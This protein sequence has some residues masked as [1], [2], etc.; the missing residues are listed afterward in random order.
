MKVCN[1]AALTH[2]GGTLQGGTIQL[3][4]FD[5]PF[6]GAATLQPLGY[7]QWKAL[8]KQAVVV[9]VKVKLEAWNSGSTGILV[10]LNAMPESKGTTLLTQAEA[11]CELPNSVHR[12]LSPDVDHATVFLKVSTKKHMAVSKLRDSNELAIDLPNETPPSRQSYMHYW[13]QVTDQTSAF[14][15]TFVMTVEYLVLLF[16]QIVPSRSNDS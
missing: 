10:G 2:A 5:D 11:Y 1:T 15:A 4:S 3:N 13:C 9:G 14:S 16:D 8:Y 7:D 6:A 12:F